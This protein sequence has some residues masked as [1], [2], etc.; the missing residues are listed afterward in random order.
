MSEN[1]LIRVSVQLVTKACRYISENKLSGL[2][3]NPNPFKMGVFAQWNLDI[4][5]PC[6]NKHNLQISRPVVLPRFDSFVLLQ[7]A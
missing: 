1:V 2:F 3:P 6:C 5:K 7:V 4:T